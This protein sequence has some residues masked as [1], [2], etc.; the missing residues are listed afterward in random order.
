MTGVLTVLGCGGSSGVPKIGNDWGKCDPNEQRNLR[1]RASV[2]VQNGADTIIVDTGADFRM[3]MNRENI[4]DASAVFYTHSHSDHI[5]GMDDLR[6]LRDKRKAAIPI[7][8]MPETM[9]YLQARFDY[10]FKDIPPYY[11]TVVIPHTWSEQDLYKKQVCGNTEYVAFEQD[12]EGIRSLGFR[13][14]DIA[15]S[16][17]MVNLND[18]AIAAMQGVKTWVADGNN[19]F[20]D[21][22][23]PHASLARLQELNERI[24]V[25]TIYVTHLKNNL[26][27][28]FVNQNL[29]KGYRCCFD[30]L[31]IQFDGTVLNDH[32]G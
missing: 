17:D 22:M 13:F 25:E 7:F 29:P 28:N 20:S 11:P 3:Q 19:L 4:A 8:G 9:E 24:G 14:G 32:A 5:N 23:G 10:M 26:D 6:P 21:S 31:K 2:V 18:R 30:G 1:S 15:Y 16:T 27:Y 12:H